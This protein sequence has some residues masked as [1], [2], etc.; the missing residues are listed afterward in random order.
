MKE[1]LE[2]KYLLMSHHRQMLHEWQKLTQGSKS[3]IDYIT[4][5][6][7]YLSQCEIQEDE[8]IVLTHLRVG[9]RNDLRRELHMRDISTLYEVYELVWNYDSLSNLPR[10][11]VLV[12]SS[13]D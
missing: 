6:N 3:I 4:K 9:L 8:V 7:E 2:A 13:K 11:F 10:H 12:P 5:F 1:K